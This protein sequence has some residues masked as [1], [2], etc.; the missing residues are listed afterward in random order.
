MMILRPV[1]KCRGQPA[2]YAN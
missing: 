1:K 2:R